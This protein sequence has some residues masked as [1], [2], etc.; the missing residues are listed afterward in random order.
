MVEGPRAVQDLER[1][2]AER[3]IDRQGIMLL[4]PAN[5]AEYLGRWPNAQRFRQR[6]SAA[7]WT[8]RH[9]ES[10]CRSRQNLADHPRLDGVI[11]SK[12]CYLGPKTGSP[13]PA[14][15]E[16]ALPGT[17]KHFDLYLDE[18]GDARLLAEN[19]AHLHRSRVASSSQTT[20]CAT[21][22]KHQHLLMQAHPSQSASSR[23]VSDMSERE[24][25]AAR[26]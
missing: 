18:N 21:A 26:S 9:A 10:H 12:A 23:P 25:R 22:S 17:M 2:F 13:A 1:E 4:R 14:T 8:D 5:A 3:A 20:A 15:S 24:R 7:I 11:G 19:K 6:D 16:N